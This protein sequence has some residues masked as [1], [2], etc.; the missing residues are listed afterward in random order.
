MTFDPLH[1]DYHAMLRG[2]AEDS[3]THCDCA[4]KADFSESLLRSDENEA[5]SAG[6]R[7]GSVQ[8]TL[9]LAKIRAHGGGRMKRLVLDPE[10]LFTT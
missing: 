7:L 6:N 8:Y 9:C 2:D 5:N 3:F 4:E 10:V 1:D